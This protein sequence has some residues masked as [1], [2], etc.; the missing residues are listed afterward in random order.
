MSGINNQW[1][2]FIQRDIERDDDHVGA[3][4]HCVANLHFR[5]R[6]RTFDHSDRFGVQDALFT[7][8]VNQFFQFFSIP[9]FG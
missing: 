4:H 3:R 7:G 5:Y 8:L 1:K 9:G 6:E 2:E